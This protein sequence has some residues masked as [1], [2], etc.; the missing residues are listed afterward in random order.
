LIVAFGV[1]VILDQQHTLPFENHLGCL[2]TLSSFFKVICF[3]RHASWFTS[4][5]A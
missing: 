1:F 3:L 5:L 4:P 2:P